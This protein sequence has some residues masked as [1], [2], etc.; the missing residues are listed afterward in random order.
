MFVTLIH[1]SG[2]GNSETP[3]FGTK[4]FQFSLANQ[5]SFQFSVHLVPILSSLRCI[6]PAR[7]RKSFCAAAGLLNYLN[8]FS[9]NQEVIRSMN[10]NWRKLMS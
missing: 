8:N 4:P 7:A 9:I 10:M 2:Y 1:V 3:P 6:Q 5:H